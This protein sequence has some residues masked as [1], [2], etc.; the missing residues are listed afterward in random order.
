MLFAGPT[1]QGTNIDPSPQVPGRRTPFNLASKQGHV[2][3]V[4]RLLSNSE[5][6]IFS[7]CSFEERAIHLAAAEGH[8][9]V[10]KLLL[11]AYGHFWSLPV[12]FSSGMTALMLACAS[13]HSDVVKLLLAIKYSNPEDTRKFDQMTAL[14]LAARNGYTQAGK[15]W[16]RAKCKLKSTRAFVR[17]DCCVADG[18]LAGGTMMGWRCVVVVAKN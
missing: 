4:R 11:D 9:Q 8:T 17:L 15:S 1:G 7:W 5:G 18:L 16:T 13:G 6:I 3:V 12:I 2:E 10:V 14:H